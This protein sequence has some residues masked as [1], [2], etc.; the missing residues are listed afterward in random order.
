V[1]VRDDGRLQLFWRPGDGDEWQA[2]EIFGQSIPANSPPVMIQDFFDT[3][4][5]NNVGGFQ[6]VVAVSGQVQ[7]WVRDNR[8]LSQ[9][10]PIEGAQGQWRLVESVGNGVLRVWAMVQGSF[11]Q[12]MHMITEGA[13]GRFS[14]WEWDGRWERLGTLPTLDEEWSHVTIESSAVVV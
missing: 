12:K 5:E 4:D 11:G 6:L 2:G 10:K 7:H 8:N 1:A 9:Q 14:Y 13:D 3:V